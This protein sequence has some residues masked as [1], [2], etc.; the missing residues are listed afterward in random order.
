MFRVLTK[1][2]IFM[3]LSLCLSKIIKFE[4]ELENISKEDLKDRN[5]IFALPEDSASDLMALAIANKVQQ[6]PS[7]LDLSLIHI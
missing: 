3:I 5:T 2:R 1:N 4:I 6:I 7:P